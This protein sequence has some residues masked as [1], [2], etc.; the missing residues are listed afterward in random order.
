MVIPMARPPCTS[1]KLISEEYS[2]SRFLFLDDHIIARKEGVH[3]SAH[4]AVR[5]PTNPV[6]VREHPWEQTR[7]QIYGHSVIYDP[8]AGKFRMYY[9]AQARDEH[10]PPVV[11]NG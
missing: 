9:L 10:Y 8:E 7:A 6:M 5:H 4:Q 2:M 11:I 3:R 1:M